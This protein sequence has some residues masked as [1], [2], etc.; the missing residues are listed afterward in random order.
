MRKVVRT[1]LEHARFRAVSSTENAV[2]VTQVKQLRTG[3][4]IVSCGVTDE[5]NDIKT[6][7]WAVIRTGDQ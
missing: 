5:N 4:V 6:D 2:S 1:V 3:Q 7:L